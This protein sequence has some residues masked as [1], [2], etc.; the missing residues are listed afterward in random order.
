MPKISSNQD[1]KYAV[2]GRIVTMN[3]NQDVIDRGY[4]YIEN[5]TIHHVR[6]ENEKAPDGWTKSGAVS[7]RGTIYPGMIELHNH[8]AY[9]II[10][11]WDVP[12]KFRHRDQWRGHADYRKKMTGPLS[13]LGHL[14][15]YLQAIVRYTECKLILG[16]V[17]TS[18]GITLA[19]H[20][21]IR[22]LFKGMVRNVEKPNIP[23][24]IPAKTRIADVDNPAS[25][26][27][28]LQRDNAYLLHLAEGNQEAANKHFKALKMPN[29]PEWA[30][31]EKLVGIHATGLSPADFSVMGDRDAKVIWSPTSNLLLYG[32]TTDIQAAKENGVLL[33]IGSDWSPSGSKNLLCEIKVAK[34]FSEAQG[35]VFSDEELVQMVTINPATTL[36]WNQQVGSLEAGKKA[37]FFVVA[38]Y[39][40]APYEK[41]INATERHINLVTIG[42]IPHYGL[43]VL[44]KRFSGKT[45][46]IRIGSYRRSL[47]LSP[48]SAEDPIAVTTNFRDAEKLLKKGMQNLPAL[49]KQVE[50]ANSAFALG[51]SSA[52]SE[53]NGT[54]SRWIITDHHDHGDDHHHHELLNAGPPLS[55]I[56]GPIPLDR[57][58]VLEDKLFFKRLALNPN[59]HDYLKVGLP[60]YYGQKIDLQQSNQYRRQIDESEKSAFSTVQSMA[61]FRHTRGYLTLSNK[62]DIID[63][64]LTVL[65]EYYVHL[66]Q[67]T[68]LY[69]S[70]P[71]KKLDVLKENLTSPE[72]EETPELDFHRSII[73]I[74]NGIR[75]LHTMYQLPLP[76]ADKVVYLPFFIEAY[77]EKE[78]EVDKYLVT[79]VIGEKHGNTFGKGV[80]I[81]NWNGVPIERAIK[82]NGERFAGSN[83]HAS[84]ARGLNALTFRPLS[85]MLPPEEDWVHLTFRD[86][87][88][89]LRTRKFYWRV[90][91]R[92]DTSNPAP[93]DEAS[94]KAGYDFQCSKIHEVKKDFFAVKAAGKNRVKPGDGYLPTTEY[95]AFKAKKLKGGIGY[96][97]IYTFQ[98]S[99][100]TEFAKEFSRLV[101][102]LNTS[103]LILDI[104]NNPGGHIHAAEF[105]L[106]CL[107]T[108]LI[109][110]QPAQFLASPSIEQICSLHPKTSDIIDL[111]PWDENLASIRS[112]GARFS[113]A[114][115][116]TPTKLLRP[117]K[118][119]R[120][121]D[122]VL[123]TDA[124]CY[125]A[126]DI[127]AAGFQDNGIGI[128]LG[129]DRNTGAGGANVWSLSQ[130]HHLSVNDPELAHQ[131][132]PLPYGADIRVAIRRTLRTGANQGV[133]LEDLGV[134]PNEYHDMT[135]E[136]I[137]Q[138]NGDLIKKAIDLLTEGPPKN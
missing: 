114:H 116:I 60:P 67:K 23:G 30:I 44:M 9:N 131:L 14:D 88:G 45:E 58:T 99:R 83:T 18:Q 66:G 115:P 107:S 64:C 81:L 132:S 49:A 95:H 91:S 112:T 4:L 26:N 118:A 121:M 17:T 43:N 28:Q 33:S 21:R 135:R 7:V 96:L 123:I 41:L 94:F 97:R 129:T 104:R 71:I 42:G 68:A 76:F 120:K 103:K 52:N 133:P 61:E 87:Q 40:G 78:Q 75:D 1:S 134:E 59:I 5:D 113:A 73:T 102:K 20:N 19:S 69:A 122:C 136:D 3:G 128:I 10:P 105:L 125:S 127:F 11:L 77:R 65:S 36:G 37:D 86:E 31:N 22:P 25:L 130:L 70:N 80:E 137:L 111:S 46:K 119:T 15:G 48:P 38:G 55:E 63:S 35:G 53:T 16:G 84:F 32:V 50:S 110:P 101:E 109:K 92:A 72:Q 13:I 89:V 90:G 93:I 51:A 27:R 39:A 47:H 117:F 138:K 57:K 6:A 74:F 82:M 108:K 34:L 54:P 100:A 24:L 85:V 62:L 8:L 124:L 2:R 12:K 29:S 56:V 106:Q 79:R 126:S 98:T